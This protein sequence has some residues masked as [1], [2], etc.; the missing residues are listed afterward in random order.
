MWPFNREKEPRVWDKNAIWH[1]N[2]NV[3]IRDI[4][5]T[6]WHSL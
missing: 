4:E 5:N 2:V 6:F 1:E 3:Q